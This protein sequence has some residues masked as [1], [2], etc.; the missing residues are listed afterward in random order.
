MN[1]LNK[2]TG[3]SRRARREHCLNSF[4]LSSFT[5]SVLAPYF[6]VGSVLSLPVTIA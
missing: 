3:L 6:H 4:L 1:I 5:A 2:P